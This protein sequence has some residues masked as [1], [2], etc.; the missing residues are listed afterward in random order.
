MMYRWKG[1][2]TVILHHL[3]QN[4]KNNASRAE[5]PLRGIHTITNL[6]RH[7]HSAS[8]SWASTLIVAGIAAIITGAAVVIYRTRQQRAG[9]FNA[10]S[11]ITTGGP[12][13][14]PGV[15]ALSTG[16]SYL[17]TVQHPSRSGIGGSHVQA[18]GG[19]AAGR[20]N[21]VGTTNAPNLLAR[22]TFNL[23]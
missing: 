21:A 17:P 5:G 20:G 15:A 8:G 4:V 3:P 6:L 12:A 13:W 1:P 14:Q 23:M 9:Q 18:W 22:T 2:T 10:N 19:N 16:L 7:H 11:S